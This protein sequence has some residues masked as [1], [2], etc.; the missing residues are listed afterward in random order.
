MFY[1]RGL[2]ACS[3]MLQRTGWPLRL[4]AYPPPSC[5]VPPARL[6]PVAS[7]WPCVLTYVTCLLGCLLASPVSGAQG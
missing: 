5:G 6:L 3:R 1:G 7:R 4:G 2:A